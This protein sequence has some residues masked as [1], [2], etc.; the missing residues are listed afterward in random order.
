M[1]DRREEC[2]KLVA[3]GIS[4]KAHRKAIKLA[5]ADRAEYSIEVVAREFLTKFIDPLAESHSERVY[6]RFE[7]DVFPQIGARP[8][9]ELTA[10]ELLK[11]IQKIAARGALDTAHRTLGSCGQVF[12]YGISTGRC[13]TAQ[14][15]CTRIVVIPARPE[16]IAP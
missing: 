1:H 9:A 16:Q 2:R 10:P 3:K 11:V 6:A 4:P 15:Q 5:R 7:N 13:T 8:I 14:T 12:R